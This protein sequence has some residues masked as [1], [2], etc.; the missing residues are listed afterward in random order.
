MIVKDEA[1]FIASRVFLVQ[2]LQEADEIRAF[3]G[4]TYKGTASPISRSM[5]A[6][7]QD[8]TRLPIRPSQIWM[9]LKKISCIGWMESW[10][11]RI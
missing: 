7:E 11:R 5:A 10:I 1:Y 6:S 4:R 8:K 2:N 9:G 3:V